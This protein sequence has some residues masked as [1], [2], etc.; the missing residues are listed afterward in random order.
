MN[1]MNNNTTNIK[2]ENNSG[3][4]VSAN[5]GEFSSRVLDLLNRF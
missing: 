1:N 2:K 5:S 3:G 4:E